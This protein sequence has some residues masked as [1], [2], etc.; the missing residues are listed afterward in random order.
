MQNKTLHSFLFILLITA[1]FTLSVRAADIIGTWKAEF[2]TQIGMQKYTFT[3]KQ[4]GD[5][6][7]GKAVSEIEGQTNETELQECKLDEGIITFIARH[8][9]FEFYLSAG[10][11]G[12]QYGKVAGRLRA[13][14]G[15]FLQ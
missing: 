11:T 5:E 10:R 3:F 7:T 8:G 1:A 12:L 2:D 6:I 15:L 13:W 14:R 9:T 4:D